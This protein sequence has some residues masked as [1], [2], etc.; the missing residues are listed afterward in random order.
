MNNCGTKINTL[1]AINQHLLSDA[2]G[3]IR[4][5]EAEFYDSIHQ[6]ADRIPHG[7]DRT[8]IMLAGP[9]SSGKTTSAHILCKALEERG[10]GSD[11]VSLDDF[12]LGVSNT[13]VDE[14]GKHDFESV[15]ALDLKEIHRCFGQV[16]EKGSCDFPMFDFKVGERSEQKRNVTLQKGDVLI[17][18]GLHALNPI[19]IRAVDAGHLMKLY[20]NV[21]CR[22]FDDAGNILLTRRD[23]RL[24]RRISRDIIYRNSPIGNTLGMWPAVQHGERAYLF[25]HSSSA[26]YVINT[27]HPYEPALFKED[28]LTQILALDPTHP[29]YEYVMRIS[30]GLDKFVSIPHRLVPANSLLREFIE[31]R[32]DE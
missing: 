1:G 27:F 10:I 7:K 28:I 24:I 30:Y 26:D 16:T 20:V 14:N 15:N 3:F 5:C 2:A 17:V 6:V 18:E 21:D 31:N 25:P 29:Q 22:V 19:L 13:P 12:Y 4:Q 8:I 11:T 9:S 32:T 23:L